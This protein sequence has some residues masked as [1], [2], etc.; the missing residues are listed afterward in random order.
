MRLCWTS[1]PL[2]D[3]E[4]PAG[5]VL[6]GEKRRLIL[7]RRYQ[8]H[9][10]S[11]MTSPHREVWLETDTEKIAG[12]G[13]AFARRV[14]CMLHQRGALA[15]LSLRE[16]ILLP[17]LYAGRDDE[18]TRA[19]AALSRVAARLEIE[20]KLDEQAGERSGY[21]HGLIALARV[22]LLRPDFIVVQD[23]LAGMLPHRQEVFRG[24]LCGIVDEIGAGV[25]YLSASTQDGSGLTFCQSLEFAGAEEGL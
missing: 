9:W 22:L 1:M 8:H 18:L 13:E 11:R 2:F 4:I 24:L 15:N 6:S 25:L 23:A 3:A 10:L 21:M 17:F 5:H 7:P 12:G 20:D 19:N 14:C 16:N